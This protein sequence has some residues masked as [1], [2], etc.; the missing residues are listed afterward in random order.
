[1]KKSLFVVGPHAVGKTFTVNKY[2]EDNNGISSFDTGPTMRKLF[3]LLGN[4]YDNILAW[5]NDLT[6][7]HGADYVT[8]LLCDKLISSNPYQNLFILGYRQIENIKHMQRHYPV[9]KN[10]ILYI[11][12]EFELLKNN[13]EFRTG[14]QIGNDAFKKKLDGEQDWGLRDLKNWVKKNPLEA[15]YFRKQ[16]NDD[17]IDLLMDEFFDIVNLKTYMESSSIERMDEYFNKR[18]KHYDTI[19]S[20][21]NLTW[22]IQPR[23]IVAEYLPLKCSRILDLGCGTGLELDEIFKK[24]PMVKVDCIDI[25]QEMLKNLLKKYTDKNINIIN[26]DFLTYDFKENYYDV[27]ISAMALHHLTASEKKDLYKK[28]YKSM[29]K[30]GVFINSDYIVDTIS[31][32]QSLLD[33]A[34]KA[35]K[36]LQ[37]GLFHIDT[38]LSKANEI[39][40]LNTAGFIDTNCPVENKKTKLVIAKKQEEKVYGKN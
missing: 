12:G 30:Y 29:K 35:R 36:T 16:S 22:G 34:N 39:S 25:S 7:K 9:E 6:N 3:A 13:Y 28:I 5:V 31:E 37:K 40:I 19:H 33:I 2:L 23:E 18:S 4:D 24:F 38:P 20:V 17:H 15:I 32:E 10:K 8:K 21:R 26:H 14:E 1:M 27:V 11:D